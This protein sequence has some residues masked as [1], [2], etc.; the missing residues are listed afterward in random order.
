MRAR[1]KRRRALV[2]SG[3]GAERSVQRRER[4]AGIC[5]RRGRWGWAFVLPSL[6]FFGLFSVYPVLNALYLSFFQKHLLS[7][8][9]PKFIGFGNYLYLFRSSTFWN[10]VTATAIFTGGAFAMLV[11]LS[12]LLALFISSRK[13]FQR[14]LQLAFFSPAV[15][16]TVVAAAIWLLIFDPRGI[17]N[18]LVNA[19][20][21]T[22]G[23]DQKWLVVPGML[24]LAT[25]L[26]YV[27]K[28]VGYFTI[29]F[30]AGISSIPRSL[31]EA[32]RVDGASV[33]QTFWRVTFPLLKPTTLLVS[34]VA[35]IQC[36]RTFSTQYL[37]SQAGSPRAPID[38][39]T[40]NVYHTAIR[41]F[42]IGRASALSIILFAVMLFLSWL[43]FRLARSE[44]V[45]Y[46]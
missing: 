4:S 8:A 5:Q 27:W 31:H 46:L 2:F 32:A 43:Q 23:V 33:W 12:L 1:A 44:E 21:G 17:A 16:S 22:P 18:Q 35:M 29:I 45:S 14:F 13:R 19:V 20:A 11:G 7:N 39:I 30:I 25:M 9:P 40:L 24:Q 28:Y 3:E 6:V 26:V 15:V 10:S 37:F 36:L 38:V 34:V 42:Q 41:T